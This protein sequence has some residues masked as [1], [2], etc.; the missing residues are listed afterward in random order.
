VRE[1][2][3]QRSRVGMTTETSGPVDDPRDLSCG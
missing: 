3:C 2:R 1:S